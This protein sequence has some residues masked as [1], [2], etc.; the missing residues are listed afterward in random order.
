[1]RGTFQHIVF[2]L[3]VTSVVIGLEFFLNQFLG[4]MWPAVVRADPL[5]AF[6]AYKFHIYFLIYW[7]I[8]GASGAYDFHTKLQRSELTTAQLETQLVQA[9]VQALKMQ[10][11]PHFLFNT[12]HAIIS[13][14]LQNENSAAIKM[15]RS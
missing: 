1:M 6:V 10:L 9:Q 2:G 7:L 5:V 11:D 3:L 14:M 8:V 12:H 4:R 15:L 13:L